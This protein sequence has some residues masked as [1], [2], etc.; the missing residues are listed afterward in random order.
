MNINGVGLLKDK[1]SFDF[2][3]ILDLF[4]G[5]EL[6]DQFNID[7]LKL[8]SRFTF[9]PDQQI[10]FD[11][12]L[13]II[14][15]GNNTKVDFNT[16][17]V[18]NNLSSKL[19]INSKNL[20]FDIDVNG[21]LLDGNLEASSIIFLENIPAKNI[22]NLSAE[23]NIKIDFSDENNIKFNL[24]FEEINLKTSSEKIYLSDLND[25][26]DFLDYNFID[27]TKKYD[28][29]LEWI[30][31]RINLESNLGYNILINGYYK[32]END[33]DLNFNLSNL[34]INNFFE[35]N[36][37]PISGDIDSKINLNRSDTN[38]TISL[39]SSINDI[40]IKEYE[41]GDLEI[42]TF[43]N[44][45]FDSYSINLKLSDKDKTPIY[46]EGTIIAINENS[47]ID[48]D[49]IIDNFDISFINKIGNNSI[50]D[51]SS[52]IS[53]RV[54]LWGDL[55]KLQHDGSLNLN[56]S[57]FSIPYTNINYEIAEN[58]KIILYN[59]DFEFNDIIINHN[60][61]KT[62][63]KLN[64]KISHINYK[65]WN[66][67]LSFE[68]DRFFV[69]NK[70][71]NEKEVFFGKGF[72]GGIININGPTNQIGINVQGKTE[73][74]TELSIPRSEE[75]SIENFS[76]I[77]FID[78]NNIKES[79]VGEENL[80]STIIPKTL[81]LLIDL[82]IND[83]AL[84]DIT[85]DPQTGSYL[86]GRGIGNLIMEIDSESEFNIYGD[87]ITSEG[88]YNFKDL[89]LVDKKFNLQ[90]GGTIVWDG[91]PLE[92]QMNI[93]ALYSV[94]GGAN[95]ALLLDNPNF[96]K[97]IPTDVQINLTGNITKPDSPNFQIY[98]P[99]TSTTATTEIN[100]KLSDQ[101]VRQLQ[102]I[103][104]LTQG[105]FINEVGV[106]I[107]GLTNNIYEKVSD[108][109]TSL[110]GG[111]EGPLKVGLNYLQGDKSDILD[112]KTEDRFGVTLSTKISDNI[113]FNG[114][115]ELVE[116][117]SLII[118][119]VQLDFILTQMDL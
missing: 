15:N 40:K 95:P 111:S 57:N 39:V 48:L 74:G 36:K 104:L 83:N 87:Y 80:N 16:K 3:I 20:R 105:I 11:G 53:G 35:I 2:N 73:K 12:D 99:N 41:I 100:Y 45:D 66:L 76:F 90:K 49:I 28:F 98:F 54:N 44:T 56:N 21:N 1:T 72:L 119:D 19:G 106:S 7:N 92:A 101:E 75:F 32:N 55:N 82:E 50:N 114:K 63:S 89:A 8:D 14:E 5:D 85:L 109:F 71:F 108:V 52:Q 27:S 24:K 78:I 94:P 116:L 33:L 13:E 51:L 62:T 69:L 91:D 70:L 84:V 37:N 60:E 30:D 29:R 61:S 117:K 103:S 58:S 23:P 38:R 17:V 26:N 64:G 110:L 42:N 68:S 97:K 31:N 18:N 4:R 59:Q 43:G 47:N 65:D 118:G 93:Q 25:I 6:I 112:I 81:D 34:F 107:E 102:A 22:N 96:N 10:I 115:I 67:D 77:D 86:S 46:S 79:T 88:I 113:L 9:I